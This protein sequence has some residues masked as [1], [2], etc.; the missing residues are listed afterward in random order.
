MKYIDSNIFILA[1]LNT[2]EE[3]IKARKIISSLSSGEE[4]VTSYLTLDE[5]M[6]K[7]KKFR[8]QK[9]AVI[10]AEAIIST[11]NL[12]LITVDDE[13]ATKAINAMK[14]SNLDPRDAIH[15][16]SM[17]KAGV[18]QIISLDSDFDKIPG[19]KRIKI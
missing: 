6:W 17:K 18:T 16:A 2:E 7:V 5:V 14:E 1:L 9:D 3:G 19:I 8:G 10:A 12:I 15:L 4:A 13:V 11:P